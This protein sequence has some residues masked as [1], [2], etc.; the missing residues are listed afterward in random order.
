M[1]KRRAGE[2]DARDNG[3]KS[4]RPVLTQL[5]VMLLAVGSTAAGDDDSTLSFDLINTAGFNMQIA[6]CS[7][8]NAPSHLWNGLIG[9]N[10]KRADNHHDSL[11]SINKQVT[12]PGKGYEKRLAVRGSMNP[13]GYLAAA[14]EKTFELDVHQL[15]CDVFPEEHVKIDI[16]R[17]SLATR[18]L[19]FDVGT[20]AVLGAATIVGLDPSN[21]QAYLKVEFT[22]ERK[23]DVI[24]TSQS[25]DDTFTFLRQAQSGAAK[26]RKEEDFTLFLWRRGRERALSLYVIAPE[27][28]DV[29]VAAE[30]YSFQVMVCFF[31]FSQCVTLQNPG[32]PT[33]V[34]PSIIA[35]TIVVAV[36]FGVGLGIIFWARRRKRAR[37]RSARSRSPG[38]EANNA[39]NDFCELADNSKPLFEGLP[40]P[41]PTAPGSLASREETTKLCSVR[42]TSELE[43]VD[44][45]ISRQESEME[46]HAPR[47][48]TTIAQE[49]GSDD[50][51]AS[52][53][54]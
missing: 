27:G 46:S 49:A 40:P 18:S 36:S 41:P 42:S 17:R 28:S 22:R 48:A 19:H 6:V 7:T 29:A 24:N 31:N 15:K 26:D 35:G 11:A 53:L 25:R 51:V 12:G 13:P 3:K 33:W 54:V 32:W 44:L 9:I 47:P 30:N 38:P 16:D 4:K 52:K 45:K 5:L 2:V 37:S 50:S 14:F 39:Q 20:S 34:V 10:L 21:F 43:V 1:A 23:N 8:K